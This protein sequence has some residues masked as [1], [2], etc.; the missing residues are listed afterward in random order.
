MIYINELP[1]QVQKIL[2]SVAELQLAENGCDTL[3]V[4][5]DFENEKIKDVCSILQDY[6]NEKYEIEALQGIF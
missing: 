5:A 1:K 2:Y 4:L 6:I 3:T